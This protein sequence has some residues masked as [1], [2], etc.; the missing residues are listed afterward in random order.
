[1]GRPP[2]FPSAKSL[3]T[4]AVDTVTVFEGSP[5]ALKSIQ[6]KDAASSELPGF[7][8]STIATRLKPSSRLNY[9]MPRRPSAIS[10]R[11]LMCWE[12]TQIGS[13]SGASPRVGTLL[14]WSG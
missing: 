9:M 4:A 5:G 7:G 6:P 2:H 11:M 12:S 1:M 3:V 14:R 10:A 13:A 8:R